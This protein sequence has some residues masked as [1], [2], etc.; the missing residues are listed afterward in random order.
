MALPN[1][2]FKAALGATQ[3][4]RGVDDTRLADILNRTRIEVRYTYR[5]AG[6]LLGQWY[7]R[8]SW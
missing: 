8:G 1:F 4:L 5:A 2:F 3:L 7:V 6:R